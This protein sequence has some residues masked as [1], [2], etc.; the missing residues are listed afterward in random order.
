MAE[1]RLG[2]LQ[3]QAARRLHAHTTGLRR[4]VITVNGLRIPL[5]RG[6]EGPPLLLVHGFGDRGETWAMLSLWLRKGFE[7]LI[8]DLPGFGEAD[9][10]PSARASVPA[11]ADFLADLLDVADVGQAHVAGQ[12][13]GGAV[14]ASFAVRHGERLRTLMLISAAGPLGLDAEFE[15]LVLAGKNPLL[16]RSLADFDH[17]LT[18]SF[19]GRP[20]FPRALRRHLAAQ[21]SA[22][23]GEHEQHFARLMDPEEGEG[24]AVDLGAIHVP[25]LIVSGRDER[26]VHPGNARAY[27]DAIPM[28]E[29]VMLDGCGHCP[30]LEATARLARV[31]RSFLAQHTPHL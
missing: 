30:H 28:A 12:S 6:G 3:Y 8:P 5:L 22:R 29:L 10:I 16:T 17:L 20:P 7:L 27:L 25:T 21:W 2:R 4:Q 18:F 13:M 11:Q 23:R 1:H 26:V 24:V 15:R 31:M 9:P 14:A 19:S